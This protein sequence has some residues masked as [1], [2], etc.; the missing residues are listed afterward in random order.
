MANVSGTGYCPMATSTSKAHDYACTT[1]LN[2]KN[3]LMESVVITKDITP[4]C[5][6]LNN[7]DTQYRYFCVLYAGIGERGR[8]A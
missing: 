6:Q 1:P 5:M 4:S 3:N 2:V 7:N 8:N